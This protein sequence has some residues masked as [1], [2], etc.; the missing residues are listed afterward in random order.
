[1]DEEGSTDRLSRLDEN[2]ARILLTAVLVVVYLESFLWTT[3]R[4]FFLNFS[5]AGPNATAVLFLFLVTGWSLGVVALADFDD[6]TTYV[7][8]TAVLVVGFVV[9]LLDSPVTAAVGSIAV[10][11]GVTPMLVGMLD[12]LR[13]K[14]VVGVGVGVLL[15]VGLRAV[16]VTASP[17]ATTTGL[18]LLSVFVALA[19]VLVFLLVARDGLPSTD[20]RN[21]DASPA[22]LGALLVVS[23]AFFAYPHVVARWELRSY[24]ASVVTLVAGVLVGLAVLHAR[25]DV[26]NR[27]LVVA[28]VVFV[29]GVGSFLYVPHPVTTVAYGVAWASAVVLLSAGSRRTEDVGTGAVPLTAFQFVAVLVLFG[30]VSA[31]NWPFMPS[32][33]DGMRGLATEAVFALHAVFPFSVLYAVS[34][35]DVSDV[36]VEE[37]SFSRR[38]LIGSA[39]VSLLPLGGLASAHSERGEEPSEEDATVPVRVMA[40][41][42]HLFLEGGESGQYNLEEARR[43]IEEDGPDVIGV[44]ESDGNR[45]TSGHVDGIEWL[46]ENLGYHTAF[47]A[48]TSTR[49]PGVS[50]LSRWPIEDV[51][52]FELPISRSPTRVVTVATVRTPNGPMRV[53]VTHFMT[54]KEG[55][56]RD[57]QAEALVEIL[58]DEEDAVILGDFNV[59]PDREEPAYRVLDDAFD[60]AWVVAEETVGGPNTWSASDPVRR[61]DY[62]FLKGDWRVHEAEVSGTPRASDHLA[63]SA[64][65]EPSDSDV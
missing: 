30:V 49:T 51:E 20:W 24:G 46:G 44:L 2:L 50:I 32:P 14:V 34:R 4:V 52:Y 6:R 64:E 26:T 37:P 5:T 23:A 38:A 19:V 48:P 27:E 47:G 16:L 43:I 29:T 36:S 57:E 61:I 28:G 33:L 25:K 7:V 1:M 59:V 13:E 17:Y 65:I 39:V 18:I 41:N 42:L 3:T 58:E 21:L 22:P 31:T 40:Y 11:T 53:A 63:V 54:G 45:A 56:V 62:V 12:D 8:L 10:M 55:D 35:Q 9:S 15:A 60:D